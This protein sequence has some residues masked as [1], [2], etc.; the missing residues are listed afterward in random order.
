M[1]LRI[2][3]AGAH[4]TGKTTL[5]QNLAKVL[6]Q[7]L[8][9]NPVRESF[10]QLGFSPSDDLDIAKRLL[11]QNM[12]LNKFNARSREHDSF[13]CDRTPFDYAAYLMSEI[14][15]KMAKTMTPIDEDFFVKYLHDC[16]MASYH[17]DLVFIVQPGIRVVDAEYKGANSQAL[18][19]HLNDLVKARAAH[20]KHKG[21]VIIP[22]WM[23][24]LDERMTFIHQQVMSFINQRNLL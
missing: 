18:M 4:R 14:N 5:A 21:V 1:S 8:L 7:P 22:R 9:D 13:V 2:G 3:F 16:N 20:T 6:R 23:T 11:V 24:D 15:N 19:E 10:E 12:V 17:L